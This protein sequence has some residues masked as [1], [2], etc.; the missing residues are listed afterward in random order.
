M[1]PPRHVSRGFSKSEDAGAAIWGGNNKYA[2]FGDLSGV[3][4][5]IVRTGDEREEFLAFVGVEWAT[6]SDDVV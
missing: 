5:A 6:D 1:G 4:M 2:Q 3:A